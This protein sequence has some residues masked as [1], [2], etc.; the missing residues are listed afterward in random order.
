MQVRD[1]L[2]EDTWEGDMVGLVGVRVGAGT[3]VGMSSTKKAVLLD[4]QAE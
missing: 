3:H 1:L 4:R 2:S